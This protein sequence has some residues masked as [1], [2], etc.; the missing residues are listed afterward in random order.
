M[1]TRLGRILQNRFVP[2]GF[3]HLLDLRALELGDGF[4]V[5]DGSGGKGDVLA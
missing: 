5:C 3:Q 4:S 2:L 1:V